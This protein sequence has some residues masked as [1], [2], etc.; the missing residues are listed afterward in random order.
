[1]SDLKVKFIT[2]ASSLEEEGLKRLEKSLK[3][4][5]WDYQIIQSPWRGFGT[6]IIESYKYMKE[7][8]SDYDLVVFAD[9]YDSIVL[10]TPEELVAR[11]RAF[12]MTAEKTFGFILG[13]ERAVWPPNPGLD[14]FYDKV[15]NTPYQYINSGCWVAEP[16]FLVRCLEKFGLPEYAFDD[17]LFYTKMFLRKADTYGILA[18]NYA[19]IFLNTGHSNE[20]S[21]TFENGR[22]KDNET[23]MKPLIVHQNGRSHQQKVIDYIDNL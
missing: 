10:G 6:K 1:M 9:A 23:K 4:F 14:F 17:Q 5:R 3:H 15:E 2:V 19:E 21:F 11:W 7:Y 12:E 13:A 16:D 20:N 18:D 8:C 22:I